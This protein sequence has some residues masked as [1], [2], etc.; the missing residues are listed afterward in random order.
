MADE[1]TA[2]VNGASAPTETATTTI[3]A[4]KNAAGEVVAE[5]VRYDYPDGTKK[6]IWK[7]PDGAW[8][9]NGTPLED[10]PLYGVHEL[11]DDALLV[12]AVEGEK[13]RDA[14]AKA[15]EDTEVC[16]VGTV[17]GASKAP[18][19][20]ALEALRG[21]EVIIWPDDDDAGEKHMKQLAEG[22]QGIAAKVGIYIWHEAP[23]DVKGPDAA[24]HPAVQ[25]GDKKDL[26]RLLNDL[27]CAPEWEPPKE[28]SVASGGGRGSGD[29]SLN[30]HGHQG[31]NHTDVGNAE[32]LVERHAADLHYCY[33][34]GQWLAF[35]GQRWREDD[36]GE[37]ERR[38]KETVKAMLIEAA[39]AEGAIHKDLVKHAL[40]S[41]SR[42]RI[43]AMIALARS[44][45]GVPIRPEE[46]DPDQWLLNVEN[47][48]ICLRTGELREHRRE[49]HITKL[50]LVE[51]DRAAEAPTWEACLETWLPSE[52]LR[53]FVQKAVGHALTGDVS[54]QVLFF[55]YGTGANGKSTLINALMEALGDYALQAAPELLT[56][57]AS[58]HPTELADLKGARFVASVEVEDGKHL[59]ES[60]VKQMTGGDRIKARFMRADFF[61]FAP[62]HKV[63]LAANH[64]PEV[65]GTDTG[66]WRRI[67]TVP[68]DVTIPKEDRDPALSA[69]LRAELPG[70]LRWAVEGCLAWQ[71]EGLGEPEEV[72]AATAE[73]K[74]E[75]D[76]L[77]GFIEER[78]VTGPGAWTRFADLY[79]EYERWCQESGETTEKKRTF[80]TRLKERGFLPANGAGNVAIRRGIA[81]RSDRNPPEGGGDES[82]KESK[83]PEESGRKPE[84]N[85]G[86]L[87]INQSYPES[88]LTSQNSFHVG[89][90]RKQVNNGYLVNSGSSGAADAGD[91]IGTFL[92]DPPAWFV[93]QVERCARDG[94]PDRLLKPLV[95]TVAA[96][97][98]GDALRGGE[99]APA[100]EEYV[101]ELAKRDLDD[102]GVV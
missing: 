58:A 51:Y 18:G 73:Y 17:T 100:V 4:I 79:A 41:E 61:E 97:V 60:L 37:V 67:K 31:P 83:P 96:D 13:P 91:P 74:A 32:R 49:D 87:T 8:G 86:E 23:E 29:Q 7:R 52:A 11:D 53:R 36:A 92:E 102:V 27:C 1:N 45:P 94:V 59:A 20:E 56:V 12:V 24:D 35:D 10:L 30:G 71:S 33:P 16:V 63:F 84:N 82:K 80:G 2:S 15:L 66:I 69:K 44:E 40:T 5:H 81:L 72:K 43:E 39:S 98:L 19:P 70:I 3:Y 64:K 38:A 9:L 89:L 101:R 26:D 77:A 6:V 50:A 90:T 54:E 88:G 57:K 75:M 78:C 93:D 85:P 99:V 25:S 65:R 34:L 62:T 14:L 68:F 42:T 28:R 55:L 21:H 76:V 47:G 22:L 46:L 48:T 95:S